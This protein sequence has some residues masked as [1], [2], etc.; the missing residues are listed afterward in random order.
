[1]IRF[2]SL[3]MAAGLL[4]SVAGCGLSK[5]AVGVQTIQNVSNANALGKLPVL[6]RGFVFSWLDKNGDGRLTFLEFQQLGVFGVS[7]VGGVIGNPNHPL[8]ELQ[9]KTHKIL[10]RNRDNLL[11]WSEFELYDSMF[12]KWPFQAE[13]LKSALPLVDA[14]KDGAYGLPEWQQ[15]GVFGVHAVGGGPGNPA[16]L[17]TELQATT[18]RR[19]DVN[20]DGKVGLDEVQEYFKR[21]NEVLPPPQPQ[22]QPSVVAG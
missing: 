10:D 5:P 1:M 7:A 15:L 12:D 2:A 16:P 20:Q 4:V 17:L 6:P 14:D 13:F 21:V 18:F 8:A 11:T 22:P 3:L 19:L 9:A